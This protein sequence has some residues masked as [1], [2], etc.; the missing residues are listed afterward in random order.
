[1]RYAFQ[2]GE[3]AEVRQPVKD[4]DVLAGRGQPPD[5]VAAEKAAAAGN[6]N[7]HLA[8][9]AHEQ[10]GA[11][12]VPLFEALLLETPGE[13]VRDPPADHP[14]TVEI[15]RSRKKIEPLSDRVCCIRIVRERAPAI[16]QK[17]CGVELALS[18]ERLRV[19]R[20][21][22]ALRAEHV[23]PVEILMDQDL[24]ALTLTRLA[25]EPDRAVEKL[26]LE[27]PAVPEPTP[28][29]VLGPALGLVSEMPERLAFARRS[30]QL[31]QHLGRDPHRVLLRKT[32]ELFAGNAA[33]DEQRT[34]SVVAV[35]KTHGPGA[36]PARERVG[37]V[38]ALRLGKVDLE[39]RQSAV[40]TPG[41]HDQ[42]DVR[43]L[44][45]RLESERP[46]LGELGHKPG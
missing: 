9:L 22:A 24:L 15:E 28:R 19:D 36:V 18:H 29:E 38:F 12:D 1:M 27:R 17:R 5:E 30:P 41:R 16:S 11:L 42:G 10:T 3:V 21:P 37:L 2:P 31:L 46:F 25:E 14:L 34:P 23:P 39:H 32:P 43:R 35:E 45:G 13:T 33:L 20:K 44:E 26:A 4:D 7:A 6:Q 8:T 40:R